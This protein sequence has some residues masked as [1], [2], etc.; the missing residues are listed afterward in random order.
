M[1]LVKLVIISTKDGNKVKTVIKPNNWRVSEYSVWPVCNVLDV[2]IG[3]EGCAT[4]PAENKTRMKMQ[5]S[6]ET[7]LTWNRLPSAMYFHWS[8]SV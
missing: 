2:K 6:L 4:A 3:I 8:L 7:W 1:I 5:P